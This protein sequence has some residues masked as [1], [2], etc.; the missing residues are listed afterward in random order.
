MV[1]DH[2]RDAN[3]HEQRPSRASRPRVVPVEINIAD[4][5]YVA[6]P[7]A[8][9]APLL[10]DQALLADWFPDLQVEVFMDRGDNGTRWSVTGA[11]VGSLEVWL[12]PMGPGTLV[13]WY[14]RGA[15]SRGRRDPSARWVAL[16]KARMFGFK[17][18][19]EGAA[20][21]K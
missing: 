2:G 17:D 11:V 20:S 4:E 16:L 6:R 21:G 13:H 9:L 7:A 3:P 19:A 15:P 1:P 8:E 18:A 14:L 12:E 5:T 10:V